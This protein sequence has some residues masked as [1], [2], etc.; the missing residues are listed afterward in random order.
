[1]NVLTHAFERCG[2]D[3]PPSSAQSSLFFISIVLRSAPFTTVT[4]LANTQNIGELLSMM[5]I[6]IRT[7]VCSS[8][9]TSSGASAS[10]RFLSAIQLSGISTVRDFNCPAEIQ[11]VR[12][13]VDVAH[14]CHA[15]KHVFEV[16][17]RKCVS[18]R[19][20]FSG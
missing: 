3:M 2:H 19:R 5:L 12:N 8:P 15:V 6:M 13:A 14:S 7:A 16:A 20:V 18:T 9:F 1:M 10:N 17:E 4:A 11:K